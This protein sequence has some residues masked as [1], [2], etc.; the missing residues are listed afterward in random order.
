MGLWFVLT[1]VWPNQGSGHGLT[2]GKERVKSCIEKFGGTVMMSFSCL[3]DAL[4]AGKAPG[5]KKII[6][7]HNRS[8]KIITLEQLNDIILGDLLLED[9]YKL[10]SNIGNFEVSYIALL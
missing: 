1:W 9:L 3:T 2:L 7:A 4:V 6:K 10:I 5:P 8:K